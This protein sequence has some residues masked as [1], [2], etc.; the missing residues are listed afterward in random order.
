MGDGPESGCIKITDLGM[1]RTFHSPLRPLADVDSVV[2]TCW[3]RAPELFLG[4]RHYTKA[5]DIFSIGCIFAELLTNLPIFHCIQDKGEQQ[6]RSPYQF[7]QLDKMFSILGF[8]MPKDWEGLKML[9]EYGKLMQEFTK[10]RSDIRMSMAVV[11][12]IE[13]FFY[14]ETDIAAAISHG[15]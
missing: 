6:S 11:V 7:S 14:F 2:V 8:P 10:N 5:I 9:P 13:I 1:A 4:S 15:I 3:Y 12:I